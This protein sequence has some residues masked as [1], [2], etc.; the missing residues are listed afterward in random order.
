MDANEEEEDADATI[1]GNRN[2]TMMMSHPIQL[3]LL[4]G[5]S[6]VLVEEV[7]AGHLCAI[8]NLENIPYK[9]TTL[10]DSAHG[11]PPRGFTN[12]GMRPLVK[13]NVEAVNLNDTGSLEHGL[14]K[15]SLADAAGEVTTTSRGERILPCL[16]ELHLEQSIIDLQCVHSDR[17]DIELRISEPIVEFGETTDWFSEYVNTDFDGFLDKQS[18]MLPVRQLS[19]PPYNEEEG[20]DYTDCG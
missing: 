11:M 14:A 8:K 20:I 10:C 19:I 16:G 6:F 13:V 5:L 12:Q 9:T 17:K 3:H 18:T 4:M 1:T 7:P 15:L 2:Q